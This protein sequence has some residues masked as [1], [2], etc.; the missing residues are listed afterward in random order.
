MNEAFKEA[1]KG[2]AGL[3]FH[4]LIATNAPTLFKGILVELLRQGKVTVNDLVPLIEGNKSLWKSGLFP[5]DY[6]EKLRVA[7]SRVGD[8]DWLTAAWCIEA[9]RQDHPALASLFISWKKAHNWLGRQIA[10]VK[11]EASRNGD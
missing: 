1:L 2:F 7:A 10:E 5:I 11:L 8:T 9:I 3:T 4:G 6:V